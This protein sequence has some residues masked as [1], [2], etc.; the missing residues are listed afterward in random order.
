MLK[1]GQ[2]LLPIPSS[3][4]QRKPLLMVWSHIRQHSVHLQTCVY[5]CIQIHFLWVLV[6]HQCLIFQ[7]IEIIIII[8]PLSSFLQ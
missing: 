2:M 1:T 5:F 7:G 4:L 6:S 8:N 3:T